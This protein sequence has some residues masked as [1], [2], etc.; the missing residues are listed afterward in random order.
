MG[1]GIPA[2]AGRL[3]TVGPFAPHRHGR[4]LFRT[5]AV[6]VGGL[7]ATAALFDYGFGRLQEAIVPASNAW[8]DGNLTLIERRIAEAPAGER[9]AAVAALER[10]LGFPVGLLPL[11][12]V[13]RFGDAATER[14]SEMFDEQG[15]ATFLRMS[16]RL[17]AAIRIG[18]IAAAD[19]APRSRLLDAVP[20][21]F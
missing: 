9:D 1:Q 12:S 16:Q 8:V 19:D 5:Y 2:G 10:E 15:R 3:V 14:T 21:L 11:D 17:G 18:P 20:H 6:I 13:V 7:I 4:L